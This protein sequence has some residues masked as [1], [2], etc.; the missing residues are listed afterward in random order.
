MIYLHFKL[1]FCFLIYK[2]CVSNGMTVLKLK[3]N[4]WWFLTDRVFSTTETTDD[5]FSE[6][7]MPIVAGAMRGFNG[8]SFH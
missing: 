8:K 3:S 5:V 4:M 7:A 2:L 1:Y 6:I